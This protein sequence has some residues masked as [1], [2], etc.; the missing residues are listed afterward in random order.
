M[1]LDKFEQIKMRKQMLDLCGFR[2][3]F[4]KSPPSA[5]A[6]YASIWIRNYFAN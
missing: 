5:I 4:F 1:N 2:S 6:N 3:S